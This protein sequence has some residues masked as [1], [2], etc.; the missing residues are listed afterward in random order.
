[1]STVK[2]NTFLLSYVNEIATKNLEILKLVG[3]WVILENVISIF[4]LQFL[5][6]KILFH[7]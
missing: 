1:M 4:K 5:R 2:T 6:R 7:I 3:L